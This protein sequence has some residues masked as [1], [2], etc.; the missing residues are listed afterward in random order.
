MAL[1]KH[2]YL[3]LGILA[4]ELIIAGFYIAGAFAACTSLALEGGDEE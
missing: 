4:L 3:L 1:G 2:T